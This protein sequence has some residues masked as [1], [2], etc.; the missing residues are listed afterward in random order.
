MK[1]PKKNFVI[2]VEETCTSPLTIRATTYQGA[3]RIAK[4]LYDQGDLNWMETEVNYTN[5]YHSRPEGAAI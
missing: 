3:L 5:P 4:R 1:N 2:N